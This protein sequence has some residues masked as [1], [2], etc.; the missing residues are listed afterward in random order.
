MKSLNL[1][2]LKVGFRAQIVKIEND[3]GDK[4]LKQLINMGVAKGNIIEV[5]NNQLPGLLLLKKENS[6]FGIS[7]EIANN[8]FI[9]LI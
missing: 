4:I 1:S 2:S 9:K 6:T 3:S 7:K 8:I 5:I